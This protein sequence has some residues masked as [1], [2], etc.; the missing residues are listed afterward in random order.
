MVQCLTTYVLQT[1]V[2]TEIIR[3]FLPRWGKYT[4]VVNLQTSRPLKQEMQI[5]ES[6]CFRKCRCV[7]G[8][9]VLSLDF[10]SANCSGNI[11][12]YVTVNKPCTLT[13]K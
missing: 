3:L 1:N 12:I 2:T 6:N 7:G 8:R 13:N 10:P 5:G 9:G 4:Q 11:Y